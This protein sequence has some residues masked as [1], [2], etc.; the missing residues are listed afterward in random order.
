MNYYTSDL[1]FDHFNIIKFCDRPYTTTEEMNQALK[2]KW[3]ARV[4]PE[5][6]VYILGDICMS[7]D[8][9]I[10]HVESLNGFKHIVRGNHDPKNILSKKIKNTHF[11]ELIHSVHDGDN[12]VILCHYPIYEWNGYYHGAYHFYGH[13]HG[14]RRSFHE[15][16]FEVGVDIQD[17]E[18]KTFH[19]IISNPQYVNKA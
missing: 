2:D 1:H 7:V 13:L 18:P 5:D 3:N 10:K 6:H 11:T 4:K 9:F 17:Y 14:T 19:E 12:K 16:A 8:G 15:R